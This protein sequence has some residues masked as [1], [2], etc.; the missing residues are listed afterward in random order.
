MIYDNY[1]DYKEDTICK[2]L[3][4]SDGESEFLIF[5]SFTDQ[6]VADAQVSKPSEEPFQIMTVLIQK[7][8]DLRNISSHAIGQFK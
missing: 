5:L 3:C 1:L 6:V 2:T 4:E 8:M 7:L